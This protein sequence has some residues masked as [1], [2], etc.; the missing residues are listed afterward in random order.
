[1]VQVEAE[2]LMVLLEHLQVLAGLVI[3]LLHHL[4]KVMLAVLLR[5][6]HLMAVEA[7]AELLLSV[8][9]ALPLTEVVREALEL[10][11]PLLELL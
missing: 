2:Q 11:L 9:M 4:P 10:H 6:A 1:M 5:Q 8:V 3:H 7:E